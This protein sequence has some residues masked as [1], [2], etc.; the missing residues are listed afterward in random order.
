MKDVMWYLRAVLLIVL[1]TVCTY[2]RERDQSPNVG[3]N[4]R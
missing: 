3:A 2:G 1:S 4:G